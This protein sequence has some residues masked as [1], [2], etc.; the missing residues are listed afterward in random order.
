VL[1]RPAVAKTIA[2][3]V[4]GVCDANNLFTNI[5]AH[6]AGNTHDAHIWNNCKLSESFESGV[7]KFLNVIKVEHN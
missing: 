7:G 6:Y 2:L 4:Q 1:C 5:V 3:N